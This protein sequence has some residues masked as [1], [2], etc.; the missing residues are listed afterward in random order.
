MEADITPL[1]FKEY[2]DNGR[3]LYS[4]LSKGPFIIDYNKNPIWVYPEISQH[5][6]KVTRENIITNIIR[7][8]SRVFE[9]FFH[10]EYLCK[11][12][13]DEEKVPF[14]MSGI[15]EK[16]LEGNRAT[17]QK[18]IEYIEGK[19]KSLWAG[20]TVQY[21]CG[22]GAAEKNDLGVAG[23][24]LRHRINS[25][26]PTIKNT[27]ESIMNHASQIEK[28]RDW[29]GKDVEKFLEWLDENFDI[30]YTKGSIG[31]GFSEDSYL[32]EEVLRLEKEISKR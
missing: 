18:I 26:G 14:N 5:D 23:K 17:P 7:L 16:V 9:A 32:G 31:P 2:L 10:L 21:G 1:Y 15:L 29:V 4:D 20:K 3:S 24:A 27:K 22:L 12:L 19:K 6:E 11:S 13:K 30:E 25:W 28:S 8:P